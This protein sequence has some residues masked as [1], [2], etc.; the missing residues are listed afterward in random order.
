MLNPATG[1]MTT[2]SIATRGLR[3]LAKW[4]REGKTYDLRDYK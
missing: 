3:T 2:I 1:K 4:L